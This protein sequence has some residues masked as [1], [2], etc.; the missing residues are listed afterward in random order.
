MRKYPLKNMDIREALADAEMKLSDLARVMNREPDQI[1]HLL[2]YRELTQNEKDGMFK[3]IKK[4]H[5]EP[6]QIVSVVR[7]QNLPAQHQKGWIVARQNDGKLWYWGIYDT[8]D[9]AEMVAKQLGSGIVLEV[10]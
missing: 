7:I 10:S 3:A 4:Y 9:R 5:R 6:D 8:E 2:W 1:Y